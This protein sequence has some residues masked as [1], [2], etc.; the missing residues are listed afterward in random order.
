[1]KWRVDF[2]CLYLTGCRRDKPAGRP[3]IK[4][5][6]KL[7]IAKFADTHVCKEKER[8]RGATCASPRLQLWFCTKGAR[9]F[10]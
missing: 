3:R 8:W 10:Y 1:M 4:V 6:R 9:Q 7:T 5:A 2:D